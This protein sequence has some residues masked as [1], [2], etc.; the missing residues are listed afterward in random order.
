MKRQIEKGLKKKL[1]NSSLWKNK[2]EDDCRKQDVFMAIRDNKIGFYHKGGLLFSFD[3]KNGFR[4]H[5]KYAS[6][7][8]S[9]GK[10]YLNEN[11][12][13]NYKLLSEFES[14]YTRIKE[15]CSKYSGVE[16][17]GVSEIYHGHSYISTTDDVIVLD[18]EVSFNTDNLLSNDPI[19]DKQKKQD[20]I[21]ILLY[22]KSTKTL[23]FVE[24]KHYSNTEIW[25]KTTPKV[26]KQIKGYEDN[27]INKKEKVIIKE[28]GN[29][30][31]IIN[32]LFHLN[33]PMPVYIDPKVT[34]LIF[35]FDKDQLSGRLKELIFDKPEY[36]EIKLYPIGS[37]NGVK[38]LT[39]WDRKKRN[40]TKAKN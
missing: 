35:G 6:V 29:Y 19:N 17:S 27:Q 32:D 8:E 9:D 15:N 24:A 7:I 40:V 3:K 34:L 31:N 36:N 4:T 16:A 39:L 10:D 1:T 22:K 13:K 25:S 26:I 5:I 14:S 20:R 21:D 18:I 28:F 33:I 30:V 2:L 38:M 23:Q 37:I 12:L 11:D